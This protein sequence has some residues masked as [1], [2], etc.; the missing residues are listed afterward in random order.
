MPSGSFWR[1]QILSLAAVT[2]MLAVAI[3]ASAGATTPGAQ[4]LH[5]AF[6][7]IHI[8]PGQN[9]I[10]FA[11]NRERPSV[12]GFI[13]RF[14]PNLH[15][16]DGTTPFNGT[17]PR[18]DVTHLHHGVWLVNGAPTFAAGEEKTIVSYPP[19]YGMPY[20][21][22]DHWMMNYMIH[23]LTPTASSVYITYDVDF[24]PTSSPLAATIKPVSTLW[25]DVMNGH[26]YP[27]FDVLKGS[28]THGA[29]TFPDQAKNPY[30]GAPPLNQITVP[31][32]GVLVQTAGHLHPGGLHTDLDLT[33]GGRTVN[34]FRSTAHYYEPAGAVSWD[35]SMTAT[36]PDWRVQVHA[37]DVLSVHGTYDTTRASWYESMAIMPVAVNWGATDGQDP[38]QTRV[39][40]AGVLTHGHLAENNHHGGGAVV[41]P[42][43]TNMLDGPV[44][45]LIDISQFLY[46]QGDLT[47]GTN[48]PRPAVVHRGHS[49]TFKNLEGT[50]IF[51]TIT[52]CALP[53]NRNTGIAYPLANGKVRFDSA[54]LGYG[55]AGF[56][57]ASN[58]ITWSTPPNL[59]VGNYTYFCR[60][61]PFMRGSF[62]VIP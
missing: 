59:P 31:R 60:I 37:G 51:H 39:N 23:N 6:G 20:S 18:V 1:A 42:D 55:P 57:P 19:G 2:V 15:N 40:L 14:A 48:R 33:R 34:L 36:R 7:P 26:A 49:L 13:T 24:I 54:E 16:A 35:V 21:P 25:M 8:T 12:P 47:G 43:A 41:L 56:T 5:F 53:C 45:P 50:T 28:G 30:A 44:G 10:N 3:P 27:V 22:G 9:T 58:R 29:Y 4:T 62:R 32:D 11:P 61:H 17:I 46:S 52:S 38:F